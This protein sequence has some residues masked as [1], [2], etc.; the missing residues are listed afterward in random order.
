MRN[1]AEGEDPRRVVVRF[2]VT[3][4]LLVAASS[5]LISS[6]PF[7]SVVQSTSLELNA[8]I[9]AALLRSLGESAVAV[10]ST[11]QSPQFAVH[12]WGGCDAIEPFA[13]LTSGILASP[14]RWDSR[15]VGVLLGAVVLFAL[16]QLRLVS[17]FL[18]GA[19]APTLFESL[20]IEIWQGVFILFTISLWLAW[21][22]WS[23]AGAAGT[24]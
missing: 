24:R 19:Y 2:A 10:G 4:I 7:Q 14:A 9:T 23:L 15:I 5:A 1:R 13:L 21:A 17:L 12:V 6:E 22:R 11:I 18:T 16:N 20:H 8:W 3:L